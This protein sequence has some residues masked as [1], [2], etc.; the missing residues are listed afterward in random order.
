MSPELQTSR[1]GLVSRPDSCLGLVSAGETNVSVS[2][3]ERL[4]LELLR[5]VPNAHPWLYCT[6]TV[7]V[8]WHLSHRLLYN[9]HAFRV[10]VL[11]LHCLYIVV[12]EQQ[13][14]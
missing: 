12:F 9:V 1:F 2:R 7:S 11:S 4:D 14:N 8:L 10:C 3:G 5:L 6:I 13:M